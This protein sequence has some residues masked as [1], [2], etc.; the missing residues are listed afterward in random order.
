MGRR[1][2]GER[3]RGGEGEGE[4]GRGGRVERASS[5]DCLLITSQCSNQL[6]GTT[7][8]ARLRLGEGK[9]IKGAARSSQSQCRRSN[10][11]R[12]L[13]ISFQ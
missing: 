8:M 9:S 12:S 7:S 11:V 10:Q 4:R 2:D 5:A 6:P 3:G 1:G 13:D